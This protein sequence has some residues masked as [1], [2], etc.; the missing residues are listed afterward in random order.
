M[1]KIENI[2]NSVHIS[3]TI[4]SYCN[5]SCRY[6]PPEFHVK[7]GKI[8]DL[9]QLKK[10]YYKLSSHL[11][12]NDNVIMW[13]VGGEPSRVPDL[14]DFC[15]FLSE[16][17]DRYFKI[18]LNTNGSASYDYY[19]NLL[20]YVHEIGFSMHFAFIKHKPYLKKLVKLTKKHR[21]KVHFCV[22]YDTKYEEEVKYSIDILRKH[23]IRSNLLILTGGEDW[24]TY[25]E[26][27][28]SYMNKFSTNDPFKTLLLDGEP[29][30]DFEFKNLLEGD[31]NRFK[32]W[33][34]FVPSEHLFIRN[35]KLYAGV[36]RKEFL[37][38]LLSDK[39][40]IK[41]SFTICDG[42]PCNCTADL[43]SSKYAPNEINIS[44]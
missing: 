40:T 7:D 12:K 29:Y 3:W 5:F 31:K 24:G 15:K 42:R 8:P 36:C 25:T 43:R 22:M 30:S 41:K 11:N 38:E 19:D 17:N 16:Q 34:C 33:K 9:A 23:K 21:N 44:N 32:N 18:G 13:F 35:N 20:K 6:C 4:T 1:R 37:G 28:F 27:Q 26:E 10:I 39:D 2:T 14:I